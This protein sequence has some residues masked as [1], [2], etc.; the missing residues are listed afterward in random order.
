V[1]DLF[2]V[3]FGSATALLPIF[4]DIY[5][6]GPLGFGALRAAPAVG[7]VASALIL[8]RRPITRR[9]GHAMF[10]AVLVYGLGNVLLAL[11]PSFVLAMAA[12]VAVGAADTISVVIRQTLV[13]L[14]TPDA[15]RGRV[16]AVNAMFTST[17][18]QLG[19]F[20]AGTFASLFGTIPSVLIGG[21]STVVILLISAGIFR[22]LYRADGYEP[23]RS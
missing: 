15:M 4:A 5:D 16:F 2:A 14:H 7:A 22:D 20:R 8:A 23:D 13:Q 1:V 18:N 6:A 19:T 11:A 12:L 10:V 3:L 17:S 21:V 9:V